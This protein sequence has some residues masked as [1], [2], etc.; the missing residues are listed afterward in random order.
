LASLWSVADSSTG[1]LMQQFYRVRQQTG[2]NKAEALRAAQLAVLR[3]SIKADTASATGRGATR[4]PAAGSAAA[5]SF[6]AS[7]SAPDAHPYFW[8]PFILMGNWL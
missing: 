2:V 5:P 3:G 1:L 4:E 7:P 8:A 6:T